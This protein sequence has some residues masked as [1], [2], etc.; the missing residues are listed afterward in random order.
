MI[1]GMFNLGMTLE[2]GRPTMDSSELTTRI[3][4]DLNNANLKLTAPPDV[5]VKI[6]DEAGSVD[7]G[8]LSINYPTDWNEFVMNYDTASSSGSNEVYKI[9]EKARQM[10]PRMMRGRGGGKNGR[11]SRR[12]RSRRKAKRVKRTKSMKRYNHRRQ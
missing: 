1:G 7:L 8:N 3:K 5:I 6:I 12:I 4:S 9:Y 10:F 2:S 11:R